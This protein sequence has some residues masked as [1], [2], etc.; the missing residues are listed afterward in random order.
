[1]GSADPPWKNGGK[2][3]R[4]KYAKKSSL[5]NVG[6]GWGEARVENGAMHC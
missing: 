3:K 1:M 4:R 6:E 2:I 5:L